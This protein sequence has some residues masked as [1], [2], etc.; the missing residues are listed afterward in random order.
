[1]V[2]GANGCTSTASITITQNNS[3]P[4]AGITNNTGGTEINCNT[5]SINVT[6]TGGVSYSWNNSLGNGATK[7][8][9]APGIY[10]VTVTGTSGCTNTATITITQNTTAPTAGI[11]NNSGSTELNCST[12]SIS[13]TAT[14]GVSY[15]WN[16]GLGTGAAKTIGAAGTYIV[17]VTGA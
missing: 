5:P 17:T 1:T 4:N 13:V 15:A 9:T 10:I 14:G 6:A 2:T 16:N 8:I 12:P 3:V 11:S 7:T